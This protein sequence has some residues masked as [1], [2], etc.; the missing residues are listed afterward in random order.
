MDGERRD[1]EAQGDK[2]SSTQGQ[3]VVRDTCFSLLWVLL[4][5]LGKAGHDGAEGEEP[6]KA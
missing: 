1:V 5:T 6:W 3:E 2:S 4:C